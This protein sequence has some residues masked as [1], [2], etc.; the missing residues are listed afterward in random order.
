MGRSRRRFERQDAK[1]RPPSV[2]LPCG[3]DAAELARAMGMSLDE[4][5]R[6]AARAE[7][8]DDHDD[9]PVLVTLPLDPGGEPPDDG[10]LR[11]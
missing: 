10:H 2:R 3:C 7:Q 6:A 9:G 8:P 1:R 5:L 4:I 11:N